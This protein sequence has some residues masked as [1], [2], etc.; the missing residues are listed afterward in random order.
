MKRILF[1]SVPFS[2][3]LLILSGQYVWGKIPQTMSYQGVLTNAKGTLVADGH[4]TL[5]FKL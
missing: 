2:M 3:L 4:Y 5:T 1:L